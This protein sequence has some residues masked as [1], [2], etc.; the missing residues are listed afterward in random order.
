MKM[1]LYTDVTRYLDFKAVE[2]S[3]VF[4]GGKVHKV[5]STEAEATASGG[6]PLSI[7]QH[8]LLVCHK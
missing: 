1:L 3:Y 4:R 6:A 5:P 2:G 7:T 8:L